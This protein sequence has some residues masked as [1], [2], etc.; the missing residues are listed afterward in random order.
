VIEEVVLKIESGALAEVPC[1]EK[2]ECGRNWCAVIEG[3]NPAAPGGFNRR[4]LPRASAPWFYLID[5]I[6]RG[7]VIEFGAD[8]VSLK[9]PERKQ[10]R[11]THGVVQEVTE[12]FL[13]YRPAVSA[14]AALAEASTPAY[15]KRVR[16]V[17]RDL[18]R[19]FRDSE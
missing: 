16:A 8:R 3:R 1:Y 14:L 9:H 19:H 6:E 10:P 7:D 12:S 18:V 2:D 11:R 5:G 17:R 13:R 4:F 15:P